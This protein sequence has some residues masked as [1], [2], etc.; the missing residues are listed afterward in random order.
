LNKAISLD[1]MLKL[2]VNIEIFVMVAAERLLLILLL[3]V[4]TSLAILLL[5]F[6]VSDIKGSWRI[7]WVIIFKNG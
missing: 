6:L 1:E 4:Q 7:I 2:M 3:I 5:H